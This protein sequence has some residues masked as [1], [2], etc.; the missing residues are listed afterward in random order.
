MIGL[1]LGSRRSKG[2]LLD[3]TGTILDRLMTES[4]AIA[5]DQVRNWVL[6]ARERFP[7]AALGA[8]GYGRK[9][10]AAAFAGLALTEIK[11]FALGAGR[12]CPEARTIVDLGGQDAKVIGLEG[13]GRVRE[14]E[15]NDRCAAGTGKFFELLAVT[16]GVTLADL[17]GLALSAKTSAPITSTCAVFAESEIIGRLAEGAAKPE[18]VRGVFR[19]VAE[20]LASMLQRIGATA[21]AILVGGGANGALARELSELSGFNVIQPADG[22]FFGAV[23]AALHALRPTS[24]ELSP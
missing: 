24:A 19:A 1:D 3:S 22:P 7:E 20:R 23:G 11:A 15:M 17:P 6:K 13:P 5:A 14:F 2:V 16:M 18:V 21:P 9:A 10:G 8:T 4:W 12:L